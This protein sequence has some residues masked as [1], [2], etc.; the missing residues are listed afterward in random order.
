VLVFFTFL[1]LAAGWRYARSGKLGW[2]LLAGG[3]VGLMQATKETFVLALAAMTGALVVNHFWK[4]KMEQEVTER[5]EKRISNSLLMKHV[6]AGVIIWLTVV[7]VLFSSFFTNA[8][9]V[10][11]A[12]RTYLPWLHRAG[13]ASPHIHPWNF[14]LERLAW[15]HIGK[16]PIWSEGLIVGLALIGMIAASVRNGIAQ[17]SANFVRFLAV[18]TV[19][20][21][22]IYSAIGY[23]TPWC[24]LS[25]WQGMILLAGV[26]TMALLKWLRKRPLQIVA[27]IL[28]LGGAAQLSCQAWRADVDYAADRRNP[29]VY[30]QTSPDVVNLAD[31]VHGLAKMYRGQII[32]KFMAPEDDYGRLPWYLRGLKN[33]GWYGNV[34]PDPYAN[35][36]IV[37]TQLHAAL[38]EKKTHLMVGLNELRPGNWFE[39]YVETNLW[40]AYVNRPRSSSDN[41]SP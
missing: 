34:P 21:T 24:L 11:D 32:I 23:K 40:K 18:Y 41:E 31:R 26:G 39:T 8:A 29:Y 1:T 33:V 9:G 7:V 13:G 6:L 12:V 3:A 20:L 30:A 5:T 38:D 22:I 36:M 25:F 19:L 27:I 28:L 16:G 15:F 10:L 37:S 4:G 2:A 14:Y 17:G 35:V